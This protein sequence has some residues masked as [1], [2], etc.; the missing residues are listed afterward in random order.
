MLGLKHALQLGSLHPALHFLWVNI[1]AWGWRAGAEASCW[2]Q[3]KTRLC[4][5]REGMS[6]CPAPANSSPGTR[7]FLLHESSPLTLKVLHVIAVARWKALVFLQQNPGNYLYKCICSY[8]CI[9]SAQI[10][11]QGVHQRP[12]C[13]QKTPYSSDRRSWRCSHS[14]SGIQASSPARWAALS[15]PMKIFSLKQGAA[16][17]KLI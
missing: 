1:K 6:H 3:T 12:S 8:K 9:F 17:N 16:N 2:D 13:N 11:S 7:G 5:H 14:G 15:T 4:L 10:H